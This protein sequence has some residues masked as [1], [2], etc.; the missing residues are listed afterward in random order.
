M[1]GR[2]GRSRLKVDIEAAFRTPP[3]QA[4]VEGW[5]RGSEIHDQQIVLTAH[6]QER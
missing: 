4:Y 1:A 3:E 6:I 5:I 2:A